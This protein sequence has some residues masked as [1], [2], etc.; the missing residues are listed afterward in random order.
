[1]S[2]YNNFI[3][4]LKRIVDAEQQS[5]HEQHG[6]LSIQHAEEIDSKGR[7]RKKVVIESGQDWNY[8]G[9][10]VVEASPTGKSLTIYVSDKVRVV[11]DHD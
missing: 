11:R 7:E 4:E 5:P 1:M 9:K 6:P 3:W 10:V 8:G 2:D